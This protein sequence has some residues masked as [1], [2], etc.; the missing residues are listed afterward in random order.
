MEAFAPQSFLSGSVVF[1]V[2]DKGWE[3]CHAPLSLLAYAVRA[4]SCSCSCSLSPVF[5]ADA[6]W[7]S[8][9]VSQWLDMQSLLR[10]AEKED[11]CFLL[12][13]YS[14]SKSSIIHSMINTASYEILV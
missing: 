2:S 10:D 14:V 6:E 11:F 7:I 1:T 13:F 3:E 5:S 9:Y 8:N 4:E 12:C